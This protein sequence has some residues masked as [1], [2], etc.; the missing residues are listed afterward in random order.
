MIFIVLWF[1]LRAWPHRWR[2]RE[3]RW[4]RWWRCCEVLV[5]R[6]LT[7][8]SCRL[9]Q[10]KWTR[11]SPMLGWAGG[12]AGKERWEGLL[13]FTH[14]CAYFMFMNSQV[15]ILKSKVVN[16]TATNFAFNFSDLIE[17]FNNRVRTW[18]FHLEL[19]D[20][21][22]LL[23]HPDKALYHGCDISIVFARYYQFKSLVLVIK[24]RT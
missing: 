15:V 24:P 19:G 9:L 11:C 22:E 14:V 6:D 5:A 16:C 7:F 3:R 4:R 23:L 17:W 18:H 10:P 21:P 8:I 12:G 13:L 20:I 2:R 1:R